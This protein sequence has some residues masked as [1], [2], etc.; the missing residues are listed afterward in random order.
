M[1]KIEQDRINWFADFT[2]LANNYLDMKVRHSLKEKSCFAGNISS[3]EA[4]P[5]KGLG[6]SLEGSNA[7]GD[8]LL[9]KVICWQWN[10]SACSYG[11]SCKRWHAC[12]TCAEAEKQGEAHKAS[13]HDS[14]FNARPGKPLGLARLAALIY[15]PIVRAQVGRRKISLGCIG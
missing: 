13:S 2:A 3:E 15:H 5:K 11:D 1:V 10:H 6:K 14:S 12:Y 7:G 8:N 9:H 4:Y